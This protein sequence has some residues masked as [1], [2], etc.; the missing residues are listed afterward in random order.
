ME[1]KYHPILKYAIFI[2]LIFGIFRYE[3]V[4]PINILLQIISTCVFLL[5]ILDFVLIRNHPYLINFEDE[6][7]DEEEIEEKHKKNKKDDDIDIDEI[8]IHDDD[9]LEIIN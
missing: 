4:I 7:D 8:P 3:N 5:I 6:K 1:Y 2:V 9:E